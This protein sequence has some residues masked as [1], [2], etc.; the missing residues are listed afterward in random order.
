MGT[1]RVAC[2]ILA[3]V[4][5]LVAG[6]CCWSYVGVV[7]LGTAVKSKPA[8]VEVAGSYRVRQYGGGS[9]H[10]KWPTDLVLTLHD[11]GT[12][13]C[14]GDYSVFVVDFQVPKSSID[15]GH[16]GAWEFQSGRDG[17]PVAVRLVVGGV[18]IPADLLRSGKR[19]GLGISQGPW[20]GD[21]D[22]R[23]TLEFLQDPAPEASK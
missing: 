6:G 15:D 19:Y 4:G 17:F 7:Y 11:D 1:L 20:Q 3:C 2:A 22:E 23:N 13:S 18:N 10:A 8:V 12:L 5:T 14:S 21:P 16:L 9:A